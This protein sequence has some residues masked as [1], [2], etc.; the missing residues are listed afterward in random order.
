MLLISNDKTVVHIGSEGMRRAVI[1]TYFEVIFQHFLEWTYEI[2][3][4][5]QCKD[6]NLRHIGVT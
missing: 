4:E 2:Q 3:E 5:P 1:V 6:F